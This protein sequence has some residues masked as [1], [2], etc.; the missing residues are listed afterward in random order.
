MNLITLFYVSRLW[1]SSSSHW[2]PPPTFSLSTLRKFE[3]PF[4]NSLSR[5]RCCRGGPRP[6]E[7]NYCSSTIFIIGVM[8]SFSRTFVQKEENLDGLWIEKHWTDSW[9]W[10]KGSNTINLFCGKP[11]VQIWVL[12]SWICALANCRWTTI[13]SGK[14]IFIW[15]N[16]EFNL[17]ILNII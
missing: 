5:H 12:C 1:T 9:Y 16:L 11:Y 8:S 4:G 7:R 15:Q 14:M 2:A 6:W 10:W 13:I 17:Q 3:M